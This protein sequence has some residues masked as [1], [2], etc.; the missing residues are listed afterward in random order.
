MESL[1]WKDFP[2]LASVKPHITLCGWRSI[3]PFTDEESGA[4]RG[5]SPATSELLMDVSGVQICA[6]LPAKPF[7]TCCHGFSAHSHSA[8]TARKGNRENGNM[9]VPLYLGS[10]ISC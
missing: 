1:L 7:S 4:P 5:S 2:T 8:S 3:S 10:R 9:L 6:H